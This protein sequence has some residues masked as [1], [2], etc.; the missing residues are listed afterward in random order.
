MIRLSA[1]DPRVK[2]ILM[3]ALSTCAVIVR[4]IV[5]LS[6]ILGLTL[7]ILMVGDVRMR[8]FYGRVRQLVKTIAVL[9]ILQIIF[10]RSGEAWLALDG[11]TLLTDG[12]LTVAAAVALR[13]LIILLAAMIVM[14][15]ETRDYL[16]ALLQLRIPYEIAFM[17]MAALRLLPVLREAAHDVIC[18]VQMRGWR[19]KKQSFRKTAAIYI[20]VFVP[21]VAEA[22]HR[23]EQIAVA[24]EARAFRALPRRTSLCRLEMKKQDWVS[25]TVS[26][27]L[28]S[29]IMMI[30][31]G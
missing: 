13:L 5:P 22:I 28:L 12:G 23:S 24:M 21:I 20:S 29:A 15:G 4:G 7:L 11:V 18:A 30:T 9:F 14:T 2:L 17:V 27:G 3:F 10:N 16:Q 19:L 8:Q 25:L 26:L 31:G 6:A 1:V